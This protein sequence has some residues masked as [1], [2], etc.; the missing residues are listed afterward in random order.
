MSLG[1]NILDHYNLFLGDYIGADVYTNNDYE[2]QILGFPNAIKDCLVL[3]SF[4]ISKY[5]SQE[6][7]CEVILPVDDLYDE[8]AEI[9]AN[10]I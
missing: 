4:G 3:T 6:D 9:F 5:D 8:C 7:C 2:I 10:S 1:E